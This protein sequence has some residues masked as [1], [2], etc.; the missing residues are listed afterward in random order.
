MAETIKLGSDFTQEA[1]AEEQNLEE[2]KESEVAEGAEEEQPSEEEEELPSE[3]PAEKQPAR[4]EP[5]VDTEGLVQQV[6]GLQEERV[7]LLK[8]IQ[9]LRGRRR[10][11]KREELIT[12]EKKIEDLKDVAPADV[13]LIEKV[14]RS[15]GYITQQEAHKMFYESVKQEELNR[16]LEEFPEYKPENDTH[17]VNWNVLQREL[18]YYRMPDDPHLIGEILRRAHRAVTKPSSDRGTAVETKRRQ[19]QVAGVGGGGVQ[20]SS[21]KQSLNVDQRWA[22]E[23]GGWSEEEIKH[24]ESQL[25]E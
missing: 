25:T 8:E 5:S 18:S 16:F 23:R 6:Q 10:E 4:P 9:D 11:L 19:V 20:R 21:S 7:K 2:V 3:L 12:V 17:D 22:L 13:E 15:R 1:P 14:L 24:I